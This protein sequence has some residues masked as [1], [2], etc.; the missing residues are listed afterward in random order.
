MD[1]GSATLAWSFTLLSSSGSQIGSSA[2]PIAAASIS[3]AGVAASPHKAVLS[4]PDEIL[5]SGGLFRL[6]LTASLTTSGGTI[7][8]AT[9]AAASPEFGIGEGQGLKE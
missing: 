3:G 1:A 9:T 7:D 6:R 5:R 8:K 4:L 2:R